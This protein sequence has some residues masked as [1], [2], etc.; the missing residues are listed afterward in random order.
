M[1]Y[2]WKIDFY[3][4]VVRNLKLLIFLRTF[5]FS[6]KMIRPASVELYRGIF[7]CEV[8]SGVRYWLTFNWWCV[9][10]NFS[11]RYHDTLIRLQR[12]VQFPSPLKL[13]RS[14]HRPLKTGLHARVRAPMTPDVADAS[15]RIWTLGWL[16][17]SRDVRDAS[18]RWS[19]GWTNRVSFTLTR[20]ELE[21]LPRSL[22]V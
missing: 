11:E 20:V 2:T 10:S 21:E 15:A 3:A 1:F 22:K 7:K 9:L 16:L 4:P 13:L 6:W 19:I 14:F 17:L 12:D 5:N 8:S 18:K